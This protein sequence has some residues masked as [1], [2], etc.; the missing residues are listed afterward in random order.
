MRE[1]VVISG[2]GGTG[3]TS[4]VASFAALA[5]SKVLADCDVD[6]AD[7][8]LVLEPEIEHTEDFSGGK[9]AEIITE[10]CVGC[11]ACYEACRFE[12][13][14]RK[15]DLDEVVSMSFKI[16]PISCE[17]CGVCV[18]VC[19]ADAIAFEPAINGQWYSSIT[20]HGPMVHARL[21]IA[22]EN[23]GKLVSLVRN[24]A[25][26][27]AEENKLELVI[28]DGS[29][30]IGCPVIASIAGADL[31]L[32]VTEPTQSGQHDLQRVTELTRHF[33]IKSMVC[34]NKW[35]LNPDVT[36]DIEAQAQQ[37]GVAVAGRVRYDNAVTEAQIRKLSVVEYSKNGVA[38]DIRKLWYT[39]SNALKE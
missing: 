37:N 20:R 6:A 29:P 38:E 18:R 8:Y 31:V 7:L 32:V 34:V 36:A 13:V 14:K 35:D 10:K 23:S 22:Q 19:P 39:V 33:G 2:K 25:K 27:I 5:Q 30:G 11:G 9:H 24:H 1:L 15:T 3:K 21:G 28:I 17:G 26:K 4:I 12:A 16:D